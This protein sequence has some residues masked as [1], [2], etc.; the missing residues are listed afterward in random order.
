[1]LFPTQMILLRSGTG[2]KSLS[3]TARAGLASPALHTNALNDLLSPTW[4]N[5]QNAGPSM[6]SFIDTT[7]LTSLVKSLSCFLL[8]QSSLPWHLPAPGCLRLPKH[9][10]CDWHSPKTLTP[11]AQRLMLCQWHLDPSGKHRQDGHPANIH[12]ARSVFPLPLEKIQQ[13]VLV[14]GPTIA[15]KAL[16]L[17]GVQPAQQ[18]V[19]TVSKKKY[20]PHLLQR[21]AP[22]RSIL[23]AG[24]ALGPWTG[25]SSHVSSIQNKCHKTL[26]LF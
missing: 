20:I 7:L 5:Y 1:M 15:T 25:P 2:G 13:F 18:D 10:S 3:N 14:Q 22:D 8:S 23:W 9:V 19:C 12:L 24:S 16:L 21:Y 6:T 26:S 4:R 17:S 11:P